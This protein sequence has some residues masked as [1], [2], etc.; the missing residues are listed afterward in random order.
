M[1]VWMIGRKT[2]DC[3]TLKLTY[4]KKGW[5]CLLAPAECGGPE[6]RGLDEASLIPGLGRFP[7]WGQG[8]PLQHTCLENTMD[9]GV[10]RAT[11]DRVAKGWKW[12]KPPSIA[13][14]NIGERGS[15]WKTIFWNKRVGSSFFILAMPCSMYFY[16]VS[17]D[18]DLILC[19]IFD[20]IAY[21]DLL[22]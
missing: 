13:H 9:R 11:V 2:R 21:I 4:A 20:L 16:E 7:G 3:S 5:G 22:W 15:A 19:K 10:W 14:T 6:F 8:S 12:P 18:S 1:K 17:S